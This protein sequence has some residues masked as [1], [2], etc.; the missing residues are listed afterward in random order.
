[1]WVF[2]NHRPKKKITFL[3]FFQRSFSKLCQYD[4][5]ML[6]RD[7]NL[8]VNNKNLEL[9]TNIFNLESLIRK[10]TCFQSISQTCIDLIPTN[11]NGIFKN[12]NVLE[13]GISYYHISITR[14][15][16]SVSKR[17]CKNESILGL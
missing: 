16:R 5:I 17:K 7:F 3:K 6:I 9:F 12:S 14:E 4:N 2:I 11:H 15:A 1:M 10:P 13:V 8:T